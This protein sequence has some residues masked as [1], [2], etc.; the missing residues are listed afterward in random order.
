MPKRA[1]KAEC[2]PSATEH[3]LAAIGARIRDLRLQRGITL[4]SLADATGLSPSMISLVE[5]GRSSPSIGSLIVICSGL[6]VQMGDVLAPDARSR[7]DLVSRVEDQPEY[8]SAEGVL[9]RVLADDRAR[10][11]EFAINTYR[12][13]T[14]SAR[15]PLQHAG[16]EYGIVL[17]G[18]LTVELNGTRHVLRPG[19][20]ISYES[21]RAHRIWNYGRT[22]ARALWINLQRA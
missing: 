3:T 2:P 5:R 9:R 7:R 16:F 18:E 13:Q 1:P 17:E 12:S 6:G 10:G 11:I 14:G 21:A 22:A 19:D 8:R 15:S 20:L 4:Q